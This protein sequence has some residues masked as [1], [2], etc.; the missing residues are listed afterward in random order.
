MTPFVFLPSAASPERVARAHAHGADA[1]A[2]GLRRRSLGVVAN[3][4]TVSHGT[5]E[6]GVDPGE[7]DRQ[8]HVLTADVI[9]RRADQ[10]GERDRIVGLFDL[11]ALDRFV[12]PMPSLDRQGA[13]VRVYAYLGDRDRT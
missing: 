4:P 3:D 2:E 8:R 1:R 7:R 13:A 6:E 11:D 10:D 9:I 12:T 5:V